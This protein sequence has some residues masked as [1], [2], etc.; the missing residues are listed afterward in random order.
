MKKP[1]KLIIILIA[2]AAIAIIIPIIISWLSP[3]FSSDITA[4]GL[5]NYIVSI[6]AF[7]STLIL[8]VVA[9]CQTR[10]ANE[11]SQSVLKIEQ[12]NYRRFIQPFISIYNYEFSEFLFNDILKAKNTM[13]QIGEWNDNEKAIGLILEIV[14]TTESFISF[15]YDDAFI[16]KKCCMHSGINA[17]KNLLFTTLEPGGKEKIILYA[18]HD[19]FKCLYGKTLELN[20]RIRNRFAN[21]FLEKVDL[22]FVSMYNEPHLKGTIAIQNYRVEED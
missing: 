3:K 10:K 22:V 1:Y 16:E 2:I 15:L 13:I 5:L 6:F 20:F 7:F 12:N 19:F 17:N 11:L 21:L 8:S 9:I 4:D 18:N 14:N